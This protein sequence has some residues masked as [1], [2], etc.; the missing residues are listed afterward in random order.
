MICKIIFYPWPPPRS[1]RYEEV[2][3]RKA[4]EESPNKQPDQK[5]QRFSQS[6]I[7]T[8]RKMVA[9]NRETTPPLMLKMYYKKNGSHNRSFYYS[10]ESTEK[11]ESETIVYTWKDANLRELLNLLKKHSGDEDLNK[12]GARFKFALVYPEMRIGRYE[13]RHVGL[14]LNNKN[15]KDDL[16]FR[17]LKKNN[18]RLSRFLTFFVNSPFVH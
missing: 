9:V 2:Q 4:P 1:T 13:Q 18:S 7:L 11:P 5:I 6:T 16:I 3:K 17:K 15:T 8:F 12:E 10:H 14:V